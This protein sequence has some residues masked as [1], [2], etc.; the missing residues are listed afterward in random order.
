[1]SRLR[2]RL[3]LVLVVLLGSVLLSAGY[4]VWQLRLMGFMREPVFETERV[5]VPVLGRPAVLV[6]SKT[7]AFIH[8]DAIP[9]AQAML[10]EIARERGWSIFF[11]D[12]SAVFNTEDLVKF[13]VIVWNNV[14]GDVL[15]PEQRWTFRTW[16]SGGGG[17][18]GIHAA[19]DNSHKAWPWYQDMVIRARFIGHPM[20]PQ[21]QQAT[22]SIEQPQDPIA[23]GLPQRW[24]RTDEWYS[25]AMSPRAAGVDVLV[26]L[27]EGSYDPRSLLGTSLAMGSDHPVVWKHCVERGR[28]FYAAPGHTAESYEEPAY[29]LLLGKAIA[30]AGRIDAFAGPRSGDCDDLMVDAV[31][32]G[33]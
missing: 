9:A 10:R 28:V 29:R 26:T 31:D 5:Q 24:V 22:L 11:S 23:A 3:R 4:V 27:D 13:D 17:F 33:G 19:G 32:S 20:N 7:N 14:T 30:W 2:K 6:F 15:L 16:L 8:R 21:L 1:M 12:S 25:F 18:V